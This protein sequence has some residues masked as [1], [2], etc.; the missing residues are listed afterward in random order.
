[1]NELSN[2]LTEML[3]GIIRV[4][5]INAQGLEEAGVDGGGLFKDFL[6]DLI[7]ESFDP[8]FGLFVEAPERTLYPNPASAIAAG[9]RHLEYFCFLGAIL[10]K[11]CY[12]G[13]L[14]DVPL[15]G[16]S[17]PHSGE[18]HRVS[19]LTTLDPELYRNLVSLKRYPGD[20]SDLCLYFTAID[21]SGAEER[22]I[23]LIPRGN[24][25]GDQLERSAIP[26]HCMSI[27]L[28]RAQMY[29]QVSSMRA[30][31]E[32]MMRKRWLNMFTPAELRLL[33][34]GNRAGSMD[35]GD[36]AADANSPE[37]ATRRIARFARFGASCERSHR[38]SRDK[39]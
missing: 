19:D 24:G 26:L 12:D 28:L 39:C 30:G 14:L 36:M 34:S 17:S 4:Q 8:K 13:I 22:E 6:N 20:V 15:A 11:A 9:P 37:V 32:I 38:T 3:G 31:F 33:I 18:A 1:M 23:Q 25:G 10:G 7:S 29:R 16:F 21:R 5:F 27:Y 35:V 2:R